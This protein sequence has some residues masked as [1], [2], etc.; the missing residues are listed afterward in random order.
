MRHEHDPRVKVKMVDEECQRC[1]RITERPKGYVRKYC[2]DACR[3]TARA[4]HNRKAVQ[5]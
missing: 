5:S 2:G 4:E 1:G 3:L